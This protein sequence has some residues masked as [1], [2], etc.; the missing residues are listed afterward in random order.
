VARVL[1]LGSFPGARSLDEQRY[2]AHGRNRFWPALAPRCGT[3]PAAPYAL[4]IAA[5]KR[6]GIAL[7][8]VLRECRRPGSLDQDIAR[9]SEI[10]NEVGAFIARRPELRAILLNGQAAAALF[11]RHVLPRD[12]WPDC[13]LLV[14]TMPS[15]SPAHA[16]MSLGEVSDAWGTVV[17]RF[18]LP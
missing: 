4:R 12:L 6:R 14:R 16:A 7:W 5:L 15:T 10:P 8:D 3:D 13:G 2:Y 17:E 18:W 1:I 11:A 9:A